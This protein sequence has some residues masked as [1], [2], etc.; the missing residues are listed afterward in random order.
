MKLDLND[1]ELFD[2]PERFDVER[3]LLDERWKALQARV[4]PDRFASQGAAAQRVAMQWAVRVNEAYQRLKDPLK[5]ASYLCQLRGAPI[6]AE[7]NTAMPA[8][9]LMQQMAWR[10][11]L[12]EAQGEGELDALAEE[13]RSRHRQML[14]TLRECLDVRGDFAAA[15]QQVRALMFVERFAEDVDRRLDALGQ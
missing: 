15:A 10:E 9:F 11:T 6:Q 2:V 1:F 4:H 5:R 14:D 13:V 8:D 7:S 12:D 3:A